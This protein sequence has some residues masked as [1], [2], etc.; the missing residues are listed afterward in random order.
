MKVESS[1]CYKKSWSDNMSNPIQKNSSV[2]T[3]HDDFLD[4]I[5]HSLGNDIYR[6]SYTYVKNKEIAEDLTQ[7]ILLKCYK[8][9]E[10]FRGD[11]SLKTWVMRIT[12]NTCK[13]YL[14]SG[15]TKYIT[16]SDIVLKLTKGKDKS[17]EQIMLEQHEINELTAKILELP[18]KC[19]EVLLL[20]YFNELTTKQVADILQK[21]EN[22]IKSR[23]KRAKELL[24][25]SY[26]DEER[27]PENGR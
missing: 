27:R 4:H 5:V 18:I 24:M 25:R 10:S 14:R 7:D 9:Y 3:S 23:L 26:E 19:R 8:S 6:L 16:L 15:Y 2:Y 21:N 22:T 13:D 17:P 12:I 1:N 20:Y 11:S